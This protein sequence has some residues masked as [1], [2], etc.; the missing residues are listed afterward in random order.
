MFSW[1]V[2]FE[3]EDCTPKNRPPG[4]FPESCSKR[5][6]VVTEKPSWGPVSAKGES[7]LVL[8]AEC[9]RVQGSTYQCTSTSG[10][11][12]HVAE[13]EEFHFSNCEATLVLPEEKD[14]GVRLSCSLAG[15]QG[16]NAP[17]LSP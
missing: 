14:S 11:D 3:K 10:F 5:V 6:F 2:N 8:E 7:S 16:N 12:I 17:W 1:K 4:S 15:D 13:L 9:K